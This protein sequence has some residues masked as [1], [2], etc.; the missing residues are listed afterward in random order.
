MAVLAT[1]ALA[2]TEPLAGSKVSYE[3]CSSY[4][5]RVTWA[6]TCCVHPSI[7][8]HLVAI[9]R[10][11]LGDVR[12]RIPPAEDLQIIPIHKDPAVDGSKT[13]LTSAWSGVDGRPRE[14]GHDG[15]VQPVIASDG[16]YVGE[17]LPPVP[18]K[19]G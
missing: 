9:V 17:G 7:V 3:A 6:S 2:A 8:P 12:D 14:P 4:T 16:V 19:L 18:T 1:R 11:L 15:E 13:P 5:Q 10:V